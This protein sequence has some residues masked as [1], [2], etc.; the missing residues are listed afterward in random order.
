MSAL[1]DPR[2]ALLPAPSVPDVALSPATHPALDEE[3]KPVTILCGAL[4]DVPALAVQ[5][6]S[7]GLYR[8]LQT[9]VGLAQ[10]VIRHYGGTCT[11][12]TRTGFTAVFGAPVA[13][14]DHARRAVLAALDVRQCLRQH[15]ALWAPRAEEGCVVRIGLHS[16]LGVVG[17]PGQDS[18]RYASAVGALTHLATRLQQRAAPGTILLS[19]ATYH[20][21]HAEVRGEPCGSLDIHDQ[22]TPVPVYTVQ[23]LLGM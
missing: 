22:P 1:E 5:L 18:Q 9:L 13:Q 21:V 23:G 2:W 17:G 20:L 16:G 3:H 10:G 14:E 19:A 4:V 8:P 11:L 7:E 12:P 15:P 6:D